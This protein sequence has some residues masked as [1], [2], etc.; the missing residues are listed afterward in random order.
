MYIFNDFNFNLRQNLRYVFQKHNLLLRE[1]VPN[2]NKNYFE[3]SA[4]FAPQQLILTPTQITCSSFSIIDY[5][6]ANPNRVTKQA[7]LNVGLS[8]LQL[9]LCTKKLQE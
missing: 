8:D 1:S 6:L 5:I 3:F 4:M 9:L 7:I 2:D